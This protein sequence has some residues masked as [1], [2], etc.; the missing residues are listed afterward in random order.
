LNIEGLKHA[1]GGKCINRADHK[2]AKK[3]GKNM[4]TTSIKIDHNPWR[5]RRRRRGV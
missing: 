5:R 1:T 3:S 2:S 4:N